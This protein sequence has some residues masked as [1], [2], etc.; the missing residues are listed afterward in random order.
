MSE[1][2]DSS[3]VESML[4]RAMEDPSVKGAPPNELI[5]RLQG[6]LG[7]GDLEPVTPEQLASVLEIYFQAFTLE[8]DLWVSL[9]PNQYIQT[10]PFRLKKLPEGTHL[11]ADVLIKDSDFEVEC[12]DRFITKLEARGKTLVFYARASV[13]VD[14]TLALRAVDENDNTVQV[15]PECFIKGR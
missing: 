3:E 11:V 7:V 14:L 9:T 10:K 2:L 6:A 4:A 15:P 1:V 13:P 8:R 12:F 5:N